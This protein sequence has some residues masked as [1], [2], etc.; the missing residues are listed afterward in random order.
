M[1][2]NTNIGVAFRTTKTMHQC[3]R[4]KKQIPITD[5]ERSGIYKITC[6]TCH[7]AY[8]GQTSRNLKSRYQEH[9]RY[10]KN[11]DPR[12]PSLA[13]AQGSHLQ[14]VTI[15]EAAY[16]QCASLTS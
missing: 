16:V 7:K 11:N 8:V 15:P 4:P 3:I 2:K 6:N 1:F 13:D 10:I 14:R 9:T 5:H 12:S